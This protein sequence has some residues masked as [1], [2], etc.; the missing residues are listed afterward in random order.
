MSAQESEVEEIVVTG[1]FRDS[2]A[3]ALNVKRNNTAAIDSIVADDIASFPDNNLAESMQRVPGVNI[4]RVGGEGQ[5]INVRGLSADF[6]RVRINGM[7]T[8]STGL[9]N[10]GRAFDF[11]IFASELFSRIDVRKSQSAAVEEGSLGA[12][13]DLSTGKPLDYDEFTFVTS[14]QG[15]YNDQCQYCGP[16]DGESAGVRHYSQRLA[17]RR[18]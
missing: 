10:R 15:G 9:G 1:S 11:N 17:N 13:V 7:E 12:T 4:T 18:R 14:V 5:Q 8:I 2:L 6:T 16:F 3:S